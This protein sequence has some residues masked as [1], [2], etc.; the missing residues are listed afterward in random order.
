M[1]DSLKY[2][3]STVVICLAAWGLWLGGNHVWLGLG[4]LLAILGVDPGIGIN[5]AH[6]AVGVAGGFAAQHGEEVG[7]EQRLERP[8]RMVKRSGCN[9]SSNASGAWL[10]T[11]AATSEPALEPEMMFGNRSCS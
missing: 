7:G 11:I 1:H 2:T 6:L 8:S 3:V 9:C 4:I 10:Q 5:G